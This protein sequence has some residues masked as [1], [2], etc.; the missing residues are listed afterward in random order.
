[1]S[2]VIAASK[3]WATVPC[4]F[5][6]C[7]LTVMIVG[8]GA[9]QHRLEGYVPTFF[10]IKAV[11][12]L[13]TDGACAVAIFALEDAFSARL[14][15]RDAERLNESARYVARNEDREKPDYPPWRSTP[16]APY[17][18][19]E[20]EPL[21]NKMPCLHQVKQHRDLF[22]GIMLTRTD[23][24]FTTQNGF[25]VVIYVPARNILIVW[26]YR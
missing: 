1:M 19:I 18:D 15:L 13:E 21:Y 2:R 12:Y 10:P 20:S 23:A 5:R 14:G 26:S 4:Q 7:L 24:Y 3:W 25:D 11:A 22:D 17:A 6:A 9:V 8:C 16:I